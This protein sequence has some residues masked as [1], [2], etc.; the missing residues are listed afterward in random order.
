MRTSGFGVGSVCMNIVR[1]A[2]SVAGADALWLHFCTVG[3]CW[4]REAVMGDDCWWMHLVA[5]RGAEL[6]KDVAR[7][8]ARNAAR[9]IG[10]EVISRS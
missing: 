3:L 2:T 9:G 4:S 10:L 6:R 5:T 8:R 7:E 1:W